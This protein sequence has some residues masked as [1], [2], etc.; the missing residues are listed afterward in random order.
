MLF[1]VE[2]TSS[3]FAAAYSGIGVNFEASSVCF[4]P[5]RKNRKLEQAEQLLSISLSECEKLIKI[6]LEQEED[7]DS[8]YC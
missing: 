7:E 1:L 2:K 3:N 4:T 6:T 5:A 8:F